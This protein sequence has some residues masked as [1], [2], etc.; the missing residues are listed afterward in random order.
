MTDLL[1]TA[2]ELQRE[3]VERAATVYSKSI[4]PSTPRYCD[5]DI[6]DAVVRGLGRIL[7]A[8]LRR[9]NEVPKIDPR[10]L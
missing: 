1:R 8:D 3:K 6:F 9:R 4:K 5:R 7:A 10:N 2:Q